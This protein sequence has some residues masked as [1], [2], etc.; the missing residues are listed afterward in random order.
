MYD[1]VSCTDYLIYQL[2]FKSKRIFSQIT[3]I[4]ENK[5]Q[6]SNYLNE[7]KAI[8]QFGQFQAPIGMLKLDNLIKTEERLLKVNTLCAPATQF[9]LTVTLYCSTIDG[10][11]YD[12]KSE[13]F[14]VN[15][16]FTLSRRLNNKSV[17]F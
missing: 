10:R 2:Q 17:G 12:K 6:Y 3:K 14:S 7:I 11:I 13:C 9:N 5:K 8:T 15:D 16:L 1:T 4:S